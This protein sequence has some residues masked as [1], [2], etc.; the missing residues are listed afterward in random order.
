MWKHN[1]CLK[2]NQ[3]YWINIS[4]FSYESAESNS[5]T[6]P[7]DL[8]FR[9]VTHDADSAYPNYQVVITL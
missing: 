1:F 4:L 6:Q 9:I 7:P 3:S 5:S 8:S 2:F